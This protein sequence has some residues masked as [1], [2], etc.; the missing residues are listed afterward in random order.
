MTKE[1]IFEI[2]KLKKVWAIIFAIVAAAGLSVSPEM[3]Q[4]IMDAVTDTVEVIEE[5]EPTNE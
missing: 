1:K 5:G 4:T 3:Q 2:L